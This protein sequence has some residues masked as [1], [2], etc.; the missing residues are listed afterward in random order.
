[1]GLDEG[2][3]IRLEEALSGVQGITQKKMFGGLCL[4]HRGNMVAGIMKDGRL[5]L[6]VGKERHQEA[7]SRPHAHEMDFT[8]KPMAGMIYLDEAGFSEDA[9]L[10]SWLDLALAFTSSLPPK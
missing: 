6:R 1:M 2:L 5:M 10:K 4:L 3:Q 9:D 7:L 8:G